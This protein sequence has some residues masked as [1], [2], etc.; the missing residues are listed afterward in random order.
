M[1]DRSFPAFTTDAARDLWTDVRKRAALLGAF[2]PIELVGRLD[3]DFKIEA[4]SALGNECSEVVDPANTR[5][6]L[7]PDTRRQ[8]LKALDGEGQLAD[9]IA[10]A[11]P[12]DDF[13]K[14]LTGVLRGGLSIPHD[15]TLGVLGAIKSALQFAAPLVSVSEQ[16]GELER[17][18]ASRELDAAIQSLVPLGLIG[19]DDLLGE[20]DRFAAGEG[21]ASIVVSGAGG[22]GKSALL[23]EFVRR[24]H[25][26]A[27]PRP[28]IW[29]DFDSASLLQVEP[30]DLMG[31]LA[32]QLSI[33]LPQ[34]RDALVA[35][36]DDVDRRGVAGREISE[37]AF[38]GAATERSVLWALWNRHGLPTLLRDSQTIMILDTIEELLVQEDGRAEVLF[39]WLDEL[40]A[41][42]LIGSRVIISGRA[43]SELEAVAQRLDAEPLLVGELDNSAGSRLLRILLGE[44]VDAVGGG[45]IYSLVKR[46]GGNPLTLTILARYLKTADATA[47]RE[48]LSEAG[49]ADFDKQY[50]QHALYRR[51]ISRLRTDDPDLVKLAHPGLVL[52]RVTPDLIRE[53]LAEPCGLGPVSVERASV[54]FDALRGQIWLVERGDTPQSLVH[55]RDVRRLM[56]R[57]MNGV[58]AEAA[59]AI[60]RAAALYYD[61]GQDE[62]LGAI[63]QS[64][65]AL[66]HRA[67]CNPAQALE[68]HEL[69]IL[70]NRIGADISDLP[71]REQ[72]RAR[73]LKQGIWSGAPS[74]SITPQ[75][76]RQAQSLSHRRSRNV[77]SYN[78]AS[79]AP[80]LLADDAFNRGE[81]EMVSDLGARVIDEFV[82]DLNDYRRRDS[83]SLIQWPL[84]RVAVATMGT[85][86]GTKLG[87]YLSDRIISRSLKAEWSAPIAG[88][89]KRSL[90]M[91]DAVRA[92][93]ALFETPWPD[94][95]AYLVDR[96]RAPDPI[97]RLEE[98]RVSRLNGWDGA[99]RRPARVSIWLLPYLSREFAT[100]VEAPHHAHPGIFIHTGAANWLDRLYDA[101]KARRP[102]IADVE[103][104]SA[105]DAYI[106]L[107][108]DT[109]TRSHTGRLRVGMLV[110]IHAP[111]QAAV[112]QMSRSDIMDCAWEFER[113]LGTW[114][115]E[116][117]ASELRK[118]LPRDDSRWIGTIVETADRCGVLGKLVSVAR[119]S[120]PGR[121]SRDT[122]DM[123]NRFATVLAKSDR[124]HR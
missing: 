55:R 96:S 66:Y 112:E 49:S 111:V 9:A 5:W 23:A 33:A 67:F 44:R 14:A 48:L 11:A 37:Q 95:L 94:P 72:A 79:D 70:A 81:L 103:P 82:H 91:A 57:A 22:S 19:R 60:H 41:S 30:I 52:R 102:S 76:E 104:W 122:H 8:I 50:A 62:A 17:V 40:K 71:E 123:F 36:R 61:R 99:E 74:P 75:Q 54:L 89:R 3:E 109:A 77:G 16:Q 100:L 31:E 53:V 110:D 47:P 119:D 63:E 21:R 12:P 92:I 106:E 28:I 56:F 4:L 93:L 6:Q 10:K 83:S 64:V 101:A 65:E 124:G 15:A 87:H 20:L 26:A 58:A 80:G 18:V 118:N 113:S 105:S 35:F 120:A 29:L 84:W 7:K 121:L 78:P 69:M 1:T 107:G 25:A 117:T 24:N 68:D 85:A 32:R 90:T 115:R 86:R 38:S 46:Y 42:A 59:L 88:N 97:D 27:R 114:P 45:N 2:N 34:H 98:L 108:D 73:L 116:L 13:G 43:G 39:D 51:I